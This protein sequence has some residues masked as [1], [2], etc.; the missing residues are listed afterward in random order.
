MLNYYVQPIYTNHQVIN[1]CVACESYTL[2]RGTHLRKLTALTSKIGL[3]F[4]LLDLGLNSI[5]HWS[6]NF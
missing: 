4:L 3:I 5:W 6:L 2:R 1:R